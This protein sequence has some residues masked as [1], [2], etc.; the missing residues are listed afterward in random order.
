MTTALEG[1]KII[2]FTS[3]VSGPFAGV[4]L[5][6][7]GADVIKVEPPGKGD[8]FRGWGAAEYSA[9]FGSVNRNKKSVVLDLKSDAGMEMAMKLMDDADVVIENF[10]PG[11]LE[12]LGLGYQALSARNPRLVYCSI[13]G[14]G[15]TGPYAKRACYDTVGQSMS[16][17][18]G[19]LTDFENPAPMGISLSDHLAGFTAAYGI[20]GALMAREQTG[21]GQ[22]V[23]TSLLQ[24][25]IAFLGEVSARYF[26]DGEIPM[27]ATRMRK[28][29]VFAFVAKDGLPF[30]IHLS[31]PP[32]FW[33]ALTRAL[34]HE[35]WQ[36][37]ER[38]TDRNMRGRNHAVLIKMM[39]EIFKT[40]TRENW[41]AKLEA[42]DVASGPIY[43]IKEMFDDPQVQHLNMKLEVPHPILGSVSLVGSGV[44][45]SDTPPRIT[46]AAPAL[47]ADNETVLANL[48]DKVTE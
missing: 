17:L 44:N 16:G 3:Y 41:L 37:D 20:L 22:K 48:L 23:E 7:L 32:K 24:S 1:I 29:N 26:E 12:R 33:E 43:N 5:A 10:R 19:L 4:L 34:G 2:E 39:T 40:D 21:K 47:G 14:F 15:S 42:E 46:S 9:T 27:Q 28:A 18:L 45:L 35:E 36:E 6:D 31:S 38:F 25:C 8:P 11:A 30:V 13:T